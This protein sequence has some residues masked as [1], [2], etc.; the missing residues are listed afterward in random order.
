MSFDSVY[1]TIDGIV[2]A[3]NSVTFSNHALY[4]IIAIGVVFTVWSFF[5]QYRSLTHGINITRGK[6][7]D[8]DDPGAINHFQALATAL[9]GTVGLGNIAGVALAISLGG[10]GA[11]LWMWLIGVLGMA[12]KLTEVT[13]AMLTRDTSDPDQPRGGTMYMLQKMLGKASASRRQYGLASGIAVGAMAVIVS[14]SLGSPIVLACAIGAA[15]ALAIVGFFATSILSKA[16]SGIFCVAVLLTAATGGNMFQ[17]YSVADISETYF[18]INPAVT[19]IVL[20]LIVGAV[21][22]GGIKRIGTVTGVLV[23]LMCGLYVLA[24]LYVIAVNLSEVPGVF[25]LIFRSGLPTFLGGEAADPSGPFVGA[26]VGT[27]LSY[28]LQR[29]LFSSEAG[30]GSAPMAH[31]AAKTDQPVREGVVAGLEPF[32]DTIVVCT[33]TAMVILVSGTHNRA[34]EGQFDNGTPIRLVAVDKDADGIQD[35]T[36]ESEGGVP[37]WTV[38][39]D[40]LPP[41]TGEARRHRSVPEG[42]SGWAGIGRVFVV[43]EHGPENADHQPQVARIGGSIEAVQRPDDETRN[44]YI[45]TWDHVGIS[46]EPRLKTNEVWADIQ[47]APLTAYAFDR[48]APGLGKILVTI[49][50][51]LFAISTIIS[52]NY[53]GEQATNFAFG[54]FAIWPYR[55]VYCLIVLFA[56]V[57]NF[58]SA[59]AL[60]NWSTLGY[61]LMIAFNIPLMLVFG[62]MA[63]KAYHSYFKKMKSGE[64][65]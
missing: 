34:G 23:P 3:I 11:V 26:A 15:F 59:D 58:E 12:I 33:L 52:W 65:E 54:R 25:A 9:S 2:G 22:L 36:A 27:A 47:G 43:V 24:G 5:S 45:V 16:F 61:G 57:A 49:A 6:Y 4:T 44:D 62:P 10:P 56:A 31:S 63:M 42:L 13:Q 30:W 50:V 51:W 41:M 55:I 18:N 28:G 19:G 8:K 35:S 60:N 21:I 29:A 46:T 32:I 53:Y 40:K 17:A 1:E 48:V 37:L 20:T 38:E 39:T 7:D 14:T 64:I